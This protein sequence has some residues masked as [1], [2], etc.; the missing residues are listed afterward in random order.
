MSAIELCLNEVLCSI[1][2]KLLNIVVIGNEELFTTLSG[3]DIKFTFVEFGTPDVRTISAITFRTRTR[4]STSVVQHVFFDLKLTNTEGNL[5]RDERT[6]P[7]ETIRFDTPRDALLSFRL[8]KSAAR[9]KSITNNNVARDKQRRTNSTSYSVPSEFCLI[10]STPGDAVTELVVF[11]LFDETGPCI[12]LEG[13][14]VTLVKG[15]GSIVKGDGAI[16]KGVIGRKRISSFQN[17]E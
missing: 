4:E 16:I 11:F 6:E 12:S 1:N 3:I 15:I 7:T 5:N 14:C 2:D 9:V 13:L 8:F 17:L 10:G